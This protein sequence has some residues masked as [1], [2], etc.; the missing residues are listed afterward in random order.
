LAHRVISLA[1]GNSVAFGLKADV[2]PDFRSAPFADTSARLQAAARRRVIQCRR[3][4]IGVTSLRVV[5]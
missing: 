4:I 2:E 5:D 1:R 3:S